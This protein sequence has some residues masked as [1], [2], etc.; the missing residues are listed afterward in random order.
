MSVTGDFITKNNTH[1]DILNIKTNKLGNEISG[2]KLMVNEKCKSNIRLP[3]YHVKQIMKQII[4]NIT[5]E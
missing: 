2:Q 1:D 5:N 4:K 3:K